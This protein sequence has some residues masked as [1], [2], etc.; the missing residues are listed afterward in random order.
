[1]RAAAESE[2]DSP[3][4]RWHLGIIREKEGRFDVQPSSGIR[5][6]RKTP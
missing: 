3:Q 6:P 4:M 1:M 5:R 2:D